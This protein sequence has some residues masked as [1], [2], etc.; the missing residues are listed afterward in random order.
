MWEE[1]RAV[2]E[3]RRNQINNYNYI[4][5]SLAEASVWN[6]SLRVNERFNLLFEGLKISFNWKIILY[7]YITSVSFSHSI[8]ST[9][10]F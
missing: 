9:I 2:Y 8:V 4:N 6:H 3:E 5:R 10:A 1:V 7:A